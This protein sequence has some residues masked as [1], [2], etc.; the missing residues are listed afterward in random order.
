MTGVSKQIA[1]SR[2]G[3]AAASLAVLL[4]ASATMLCYD[5][6]VT[7][8]LREMSAVRTSSYLRVKLHCAYVQCGLGS[9]FCR[10]V[11]HKVRSVHELLCEPRNWDVGCAID[12]ASSED[13]VVRCTGYVAGYCCCAMLGCMLKRQASC[14]RLMVPSEASF[15]STGDV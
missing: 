11:Q 10:K 5:V 4:N 9:M 7:G 15:V 12:F 14:K 2:F 13:A 3:G 6:M 8:Q 1:C